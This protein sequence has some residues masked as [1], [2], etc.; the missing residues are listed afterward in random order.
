MAEA[1]DF[2][3]ENWEWD[4]EVGDYVADAYRKRYG[5]GEAFGGGTSEGTVSLGDLLSRDLPDVVKRVSD[6]GYAEKQNMRNDGTYDLLVQTMGQSAADELFDAREL[7]AEERYGA[8]EEPKNL[9]ER[10]SE[11]EKN[12]NAAREAERVQASVGRSLRGLTEKMGARGATVGQM[13]GVINEAQ[14]MGAMA[15]QDA[16]YRSE[17]A[18]RAHNLM[19]DM[20][21]MA[22]E[23]SYNQMLTG[24]D[25]SEDQ[26]TVAFNR[27]AELQAQQQAHQE[28]MMRLQALLNTPTFEDR[29]YELLGMGVGAGAT[30]LSGAAGGWA[31][32]A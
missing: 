32:A 30:V 10:V 27:S 11:E 7:T 2:Y 31:G 28:E 20:Q 13:A 3:Y 18:D 26:A 17:L 21:I 24:A 12:A 1:G 23:I 15:T 22:A 9:P 6:A 8:F 25:I 16:A 14:S 4:E 19:I 5:Y 29:M